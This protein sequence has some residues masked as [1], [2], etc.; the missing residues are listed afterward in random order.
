MADDHDWHLFDQPRR[1]ECRRAGARWEIRE[2][3]TVEPVVPLD[4]GEF[5]RLRRGDA[6]PHWASD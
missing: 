3:G 6:Q 1:I 5:E 4:D 2:V